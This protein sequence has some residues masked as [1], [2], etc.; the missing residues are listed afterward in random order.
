[1]GQDDI[2]CE[3]KGISPVVRIFARNEKSGITLFSCAK[4]VTCTID[5]QLVVTME[6]AQG[7]SKHRRNKAFF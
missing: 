1:M 5:K 3:L 4:S 7:D 6:T 2:E